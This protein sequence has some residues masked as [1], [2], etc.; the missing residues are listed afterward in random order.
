HVAV[1]AGGRVVDVADAD[2][3]AGAHRGHTDGQGGLVLAEGGAGAAG[4]AAV[5]GGHLRRAGEVGVEA[6]AGAGGGGAG[7]G[8]GARG[9]GRGGGGARRG[10]GRGHRARGR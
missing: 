8:R 4:G 7:G 9:G 2:R 3:A 1:G 5:H 6:R 10:A